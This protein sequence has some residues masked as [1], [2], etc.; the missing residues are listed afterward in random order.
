MIGRAKSSPREL[1]GV[2]E[3][4]RNLVE[5]YLVPMESQRGYQ[6]DE[7]D[8][9]ATESDRCPSGEPRWS[10]SYASRS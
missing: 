1:H 6:N 2:K 4:R 3:I 7:G 8:A 9:D 5:V 10:R